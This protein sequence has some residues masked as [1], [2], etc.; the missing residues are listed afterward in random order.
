MSFRICGICGGLPCNCKIG[1][2]TKCGVK[3]NLDAIGEPLIKWNEKHQLQTGCVGFVGD[4]RVAEEMRTHLEQQLDQVK[5][6]M[7]EEPKSK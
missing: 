1:E 7:K 2:C 5:Q 3:L 6:I 4:R